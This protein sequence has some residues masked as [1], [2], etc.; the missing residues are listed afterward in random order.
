MVVPLVTTG[1]KSGVGGNPSCTLG[2]PQVR[3]RQWRSGER[4]LHTRPG[5]RM[6]LILPLLQKPIWTGSQSSLETSTTA[7]FVR[8]SGRRFHRTQLLVP[9]ITT[10]AKKRIVPQHPQHQQQNM[11][12]TSCGHLICGFAKMRR[13]RHL[14]STSQF[15]NATS[16]ALLQQW[17]YG[18][19]R[20]NWINSDRMRLG[21]SISSL[22]TSRS[23]SNQHPQLVGAD[24]LHT[25][26]MSAD[27]RWASDHPP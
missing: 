13:C 5:Y 16:P 15:Q 3:S 2:F 8:S 7:R 10:H 26:L 14:N 6:L 18:L 4:K 24:T 20:P 17:C 22:E 23:V 11:Y 21:L 27:S 19:T 12:T 25:F 9:S 1:N